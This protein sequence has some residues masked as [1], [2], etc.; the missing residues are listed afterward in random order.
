MRRVCAQEKGKAHG[1][2]G[3]FKEA[4]LGVI[5]PYGPAVFHLEATGFQCG[6]FRKFAVVHRPAK[7]HAKYLNADIGGARGCPQ[8]VAKVADKFTVDTGN[9]Q[10]PKLAFKS[11]KPVFVILEGT[12]GKALGL[13]AVEIVI[14]QPAKGSG[15]F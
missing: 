6:V 1:V 12:R 4:P 3:V 2:V 9:M 13:G 8:A 7:E 15:G 11:A 14:N 5:I 10:I